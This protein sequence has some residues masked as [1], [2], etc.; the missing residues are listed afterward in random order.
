MRH[1]QLVERLAAHGEA[2]LSEQLESNPD[3]QTSIKKQ[4]ESEPALEIWARFLWI[5][6]HSNQFLDGQCEVTQ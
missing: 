4:L 2:S 1:A 3:Y 6:V 5:P